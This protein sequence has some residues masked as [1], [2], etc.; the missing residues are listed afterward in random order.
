MRQSAEL[1]VV[2]FCIAILTS[3]RV[4]NLY[5]LVPFCFIHLEWGR[6]I[7]NNAMAWFLFLI[8][9]RLISN[10]VHQNIWGVIGKIVPDSRGSRAKSF[11]ANVFSFG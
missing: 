8:Y 11:T 10:V 4:F 3:D 6:L 7:Y 5:I 2:S 1:T 9:A